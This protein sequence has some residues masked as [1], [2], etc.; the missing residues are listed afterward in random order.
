MKT[1]KIILFKLNYNYYGSEKSDIKP[2]GCRDHPAMAVEI[3]RWPVRKIKEARLTLGKF[4]CTYKSYPHFDCVTAEEYIL[5]K[6]RCDRAGNIVGKDQHD[7]ELASEEIGSFG[8]YTLMMEV[9]CNDSDN[10]EEIQTETGLQFIKSFDSLDDID[11][12]IGGKMYELKRQEFTGTL[13]GLYV[14][15]T[16]DTGIAWNEHAGKLVRTVRK[17]AMPVIVRKKQPLQ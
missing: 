3:A 16:K 6:C 10:E 15:R 1:N 8:K 14:Y 4:N 7:T 12:Y 11:K 5:Q 17:E 13:P 2:S 9:G